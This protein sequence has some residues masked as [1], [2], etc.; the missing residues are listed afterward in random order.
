MATPSATPPRIEIPISHQAAGMTSV[1]TS[2][3]TTVVS[4]PTPATG[5]G[6]QTDRCDPAIEPAGSFDGVR[7]LKIHEPQ[8]AY[9]V[10]SLE[11]GDRDRREH[12]A[13][14]APAGGP[15][16]VFLVEVSCQVRAV[17]NDAFEERERQ[18]RRFPQSHVSA[19]FM[20]AVYI[21]TNCEL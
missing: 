21:F 6:V 7:R 10:G 14:D 8:R 16:L 3:R 9:V 12:L 17:W 5:A 20:T 15:A 18:S 13:P 1:A 4:P 2:A 19:S 11:P